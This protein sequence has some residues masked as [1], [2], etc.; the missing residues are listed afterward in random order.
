MKHK[1]FKPF[2]GLILIAIFVIGVMG[3][4]DAEEPSKTSYLPVA[5]E[6]PFQKIFD[7]MKGAKADVMKRQMNLLDERYDLSDRPAEGVM[8]SGG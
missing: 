8:M 1:N 3:M 7:R 4:A 5:V 2:V 6:E